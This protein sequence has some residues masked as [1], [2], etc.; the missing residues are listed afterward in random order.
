M[1]RTVIGATVLA[2]AATGAA[3]Q[4][5]GHSVQ[6][7]W[8]FPD[9]SSVLESHVVV[10][11]DEVEL[12]AEK[13]FNDSKHSIDLGDDFVLFTFNAVAHW[14]D[15]DF[16]GW[17]F[18]DVF[19]TIPDVID[20]KVHSYSAGISNADAIVVGHAADAF[21]ANFAGVSSAGDGEWI[22]LSVA[23]VPAPGALA[24]AALGTL[25][26]LRRQRRG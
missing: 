7:Q 6:A 26:V 3:A 21:W 15:V 12:T 5:M 9:D 22:R 1:M 4:L 18:T 8:F 11:S 2:A 13:I 20:Y 10:V 16:N 19:G 14:Q 25:P 17:R 23:F 24:L